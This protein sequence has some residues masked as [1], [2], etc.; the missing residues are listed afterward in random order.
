MTQQPF[1]ASNLSPQQKT[2]IILKDLE[3]NNV[4]PDTVLTDDTFLELLDKRVI[5][6]YIQKNFLLHFPAWRPHI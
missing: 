6:S 4:Y 5:S 1:G 2:Q 3:S